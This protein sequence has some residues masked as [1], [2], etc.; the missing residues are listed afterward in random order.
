MATLI[1]QAAGSALGD[2]AGGAAG[3]A[4]GSVVG[5]SLGSA[6]DQTLLAAA[7]QASGGRR[8]TQGP[9]LRE[10]DGI[11]ATE[12]AAIPRLFGRA[13]LGGQVIWATRFE[14]EAVY[15]S[16]RPRGGK[17]GIK[18]APKPTISVSYRYF[19][20]VAIG[21]CEGEIAFVR[22]VWADGKELDL[23]Q[24]TMRVHRGAEDQTAD[25]LIAAKQGAAQA[26][27][28]RGLAY[29]VFEHLPLDS[30][31]N[32]LPQFN[33]EVVR[34]VHGI[35]QRIKA[36][37]IIPAAGEYVYEPL[38]VSR[39]GS[40]GQSSLPN[41][42]QLTHGTNWH[43]SLDALQALCPNLK[44]AAL[45]VSWFG[46]DLRAGQC[47]IRPLTEPGS[48]DGNPHFW[49]VAGLT[50]ATAGVVSS[51]DG[52]P[53]YGGTPSDSA[54]MRAIRDLK[55]R[56]IGVTL[57]PFVMMDIAP[58]NARPDPWTGAPAQPAY[59]WRG[60]I[61]CDP[62]P[63]RP[64]TAE[65]AAAEAQ[66]AAFLGACLASHF[67]TGVDTVS[68]AGPAEWTLRRLVLH[69]AALAKAA[70][71]VDA[72]VI[73]SEL[74]GL[75]RARGTGAINPAV[76]G[77][78]AV[79]AEAR[80]LLG[81]ATKITYGADWTEYGS[82]V[83]AGGDVRFP[84]DP[85]WADDNIDAVAID[86]YPPVT[87]W[88]D[89]TAHADS[90]IYDG[91][92]D[93]RMFADR[94]AGGEA[95]DWYYAD[96]AGRAAQARLPIADGAHAKPWIF[97][98]KDLVGW[99]S[100][101]HRP[102]AA[103][104]EQSQTAWVP[105]SKPIWL[106]ECG[107]P[108]VDR[109]GNGPHIFPDPKSSESGLPPFSR[110]MRDDLAQS[111]LI[112][113]TLGR[114]DPA[115]AGFQAAHNPPA[116]GYAGRMVDPERCYVWCWDARPYPAFPD[117]AEVW[118]D[119]PNWQTGHW[120]NGRLEGAPTDDLVASLLKT[121]GVNAPAE[122]A[123][124]GFVD[125]YVLDRPMSARAALEPLADLFA[126]DAVVSGGAITFRRRGRAP[127]ALLAEGDLARRRDDA[128]V[129]V[130]RGQASEVPAAL[131][132]GFVDGERDYRQGVARAAVADPASRREAAFDVAAALPRAVAEHRAEVLL[133]EARAGRETATFRLPLSR[134]DIEPGDVV[135]L[136][137]AAW[138]V[139]R[140]ND[141][142]ERRVTA[143]LSEPQVYHG[144]PRPA[145]LRR[146]AAPLLPGPPLAMALDLASAETEPVA[147]QRI[148][149]TAD[150]WPGGYTLW[151]SDDGESFT[152]EALVPTRAMI[153]ALTAP[154]PA[155]P[156]W[157]FDRRS[158]IDVVLSHG[159]L[160]AVGE[161]ASLSGVNLLAVEA[162]GQ[163]WEIISFA[164]AAL[165]GPAAWRL[166]TLVRGLAGSEPFAAL[167][168]PAGARV[169]V[170]DGAV[171]PIVSGMEALGRR[172][173]WRLSPAGRDHADPM[174]IAFEATPGP[175][176]LLPLAPVH[177]VARREADGV[178]I[179]WIR[180]TRIGGDA[181]DAAEVPLGEEAEAYLVEVLDGAAVKRSAETS[182]A[183][184]LYPAAAETADF[185]GPRAAHVMR[186]RQISRAAGP[187][188]ALEAKTPVGA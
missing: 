92:H 136:S 148:A 34:P 94:I 78:K 161:T 184:W 77:L 166:S 68:Y 144:A 24:V 30:F 150:P 107:G 23:T 70:G 167:A 173:F 99:W 143:V 186:I 119:A 93:P 53:A 160:Q 128:A 3:A 52:S 162:A 158:T 168:K 123:T 76:A 51:P 156:L 89:G 58:G 155:G 103:D 86:W 106:L 19:A 163:G 83:R 67:T 147:L 60:R 66:I 50:R 122:V 71:G 165:T 27:A 55:A 45:V 97:R 170:L 175:A 111:R 95:F 29:V 110:G 178:R 11:S 101:V 32:R 75:S 116:A 108:A 152:A 38:A 9:R 14:E 22:R 84:L 126:F 88:R 124:D 134:L 1:L 10:L 117:H 174:A 142:V 188:H 154:L 17:G 112:A 41:R 80:A 153:G 62:A 65:G 131:T 5:A 138:R 98:A 35:A 159:Q 40:L 121:F 141:A 102:R 44:N 37:N 129:A 125:G 2:I 104:V 105:Q 7:A 47:A 120:L 91:A 69:C 90:A 15:S 115:T 31:G 79:A 96:D 164:G 182:S 20:N 172:A 16:S 57:Y 135:S 54:V 176:A 185:G 64:G 12:G 181:F 169:V 151:R 49:S 130:T 63:G 137:G 13:R 6:V 33:F 171:Q 85:L 21:L 145:K 87:D 72:F 187:G 81:P 36:V 109:G 133:A 73:G 149:V 18:S 8:V 25:P 26:P 177:P 46:D 100:N 127:A 4:I 114:F 82:E 183:S 43:A 139:Q 56:G 74:V 140:I 180:R 132:L 146:R 28:Y 113:A 157:R 61:T 48:I 118:A 179:S 59:P 42:S 39:I